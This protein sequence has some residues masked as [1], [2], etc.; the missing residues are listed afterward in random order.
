[1]GGIGVLEGLGRHLVFRKGYGFQPDLLES[2]LPDLTAFDSVREFG[3]GDLSIAG[4]I[5]PL[6][7]ESWGSGGKDYF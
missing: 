2:D 7:D 4:S 3:F 1:M 5:A 6:T